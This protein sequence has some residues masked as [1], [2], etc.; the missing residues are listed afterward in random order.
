MIFYGSKTKFI[1]RLQANELERYVVFY[2]G[3][4]L[5][6]SFLISL[7]LERYVVFYDNQPSKTGSH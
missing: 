5:F 1:S 4:T 7:L 6:A 3:K 2:G